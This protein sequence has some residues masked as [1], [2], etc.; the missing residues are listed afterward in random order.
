MRRAAIPLAAAVLL[1]GP[2]VIAFFSGGYFDGPRVLAALIAWVLVVAVALLAPRPLPRTRAGSAAVGGL[3]LL[4]V[5]TAIS[6][7]WAPVGGA[8]LD[9]VQRLVLYV[10]VLVASIA[11]LRDRRVA[12]AVEPIL[13]LGSIVVIGYGL[14]GRLLPGIVHQTRSALV[15]A[16]L[17]QPLTY[18]NSEGALAAIGLA[19]CAHIAG[20]G[21]RRAVT[22]AL[23][24]AAC[25]PLG[26]GVYLSYSRGAIAAAVAG[27]A[28][29]LA[30]APSWPRLRGA[31]TAL[32]V[33]VAASVCCAVIPGVG[34][35][36]GDLAARERD[37]VIALAI[38]LGLMLVAALATVR[39]ARRER[40]QQGR[41]G[42]LPGARRVRLGAAVIGV[43]ILVGV[44]AGSL[45]E[46]GN[47]T[48]LDRTA[49]RLTSLQSQR[50][51][52][53]RVGLR[54]F[55]DHPLLGLGA[56]GFRVAWLKHRP[57]SGGA[58]LDVHSL[59]LE[60][61]T[62]LGI[63]GVLALALMLGGIG[64]AAG[65]SLRRRP[66][67]VGG[68]CAACAVWLVHATID[69]DWEMPAVTLPALVL[70]GALVAASEE[71]PPWAPG[72]A[73]DV[74]AIPAPS[75]GAVASPS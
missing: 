54:G 12:R 70:A 61:A 7:A 34:D 23:A 25:A 4:T 28:V 59:E 38:L 29:L 17:E 11:L 27:F 40:R 1:G 64:V 62:E 26:A 74:S 46:R 9:D 2:T 14:S 19:L 56:G 72:V 13:A 71:E 15:G 22:R 30:V 42:P 69:W 43:L 51:E 55:R 36:S 16:R 35:L 37:G 60:M 65:R 67:R 68:W 33:A 48:H 32:V 10:G 44:I 52:Y 5:W 47:N 75:P 6:V 31:V 58:A 21:S 45:G 49:S 39:F 20:D 18:W 24:A 63:P 8:V 57:V 73:A 3:V 66:E 53:W 50:Y 41:M